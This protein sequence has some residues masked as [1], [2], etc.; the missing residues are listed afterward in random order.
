MNIIALISLI[1]A[2]TLYVD[3]PKYPV[4]AIK[5]DMLKGM[6]AVIRESEAEWSIESK[7]SALYQERR[8][9]TILNEKAKDMAALTVVYDKLTKIE[10]FRAS[11]YDANGKLIKKLKSQDILDQSAISG[12]SLFEDNRLKHGDLSQNTYPYTVELEYGLRY[13]A[14]YN[15]GKFNLYS[16]DEVSSEKV[17]YTVIHPKD[18]KLRCRL[19]KMPQPKVESTSDKRESMSWTFENVKPDKFEKLSPD[20]VIPCVRVSPTEFSFDG[21]AGDMSSWESYGKWI[22]SLN[23]GRDILPE[24][25]KQKVK[26]LT[27]DLKTREEK[28][29]AVYEYVQ[30]RTRY[31]SVQL[32]IGGLQPFDAAVVDKTGYGDCK[33][34]SNYAVA[35]LKEA[36]VTAYYATVMAGPEVADVIEDFPSH[37]ANH[38]IVAV[39]NGRDTLWMECTSQTEPFGYLGRFTGNR[40]AMLITEDGGKLVNTIR[41]GVDQ[42]TQFRTA[43]VVVQANGDATAKVTTTYRGLQYDDV[44]TTLQPDDQKKWLQRITAI[45]SFD[46]ASF[47]VTNIKD[48]NPAAIVTMNL[49]LKRLGSVSGKRI[50][51]TA[52]LMNRSTE[53]PGKADARKNDVVTKRAY[54]SIDTIVYQ[55]PAGIYP[56]FLPAPVKLK[57][58]FGEYDATFSVDQEKLLYIRKMRMFKGVHVPE[59][60]NELVDFYRN[61]NKADHVKMVFLSKT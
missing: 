56:E 8:V 55:L 5:E 25:T 49:N 22:A 16:D 9:I 41:Y 4:S 34:L 32:G 10:Y 39:P 45:P 60:Y 44:A 46:I 19:F 50:F 43:N 21:Y 59:T 28:A 24:S 35:L 61:V 42:N 2:A 47:S 54:T 17:K 52:N 57:S 14:L 33:A 29:K 40:K 11:V 31:V 6:Y 48:K 27:K 23:K 20:E 51:I 58:R 18:L 36:G 12:G 1:S 13:K 15:L 26:E 37:Q 38:V 3:E 30:S 7:S 53:L